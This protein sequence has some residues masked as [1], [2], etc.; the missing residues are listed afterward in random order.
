MSFLCEVNAVECGS[1]KEFFLDIPKSQIRLTILQ[2]YLTNKYIVIK[3]SNLL[4][5]LSAQYV[6]HPAMRQLC[7][8]ASLSLAVNYAYATCH[9][10]KST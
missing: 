10:T 2:S 8:S 4:T 3:S 1:C 7:M 5:L 9:T 6:A